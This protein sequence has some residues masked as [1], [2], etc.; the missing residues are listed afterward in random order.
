MSLKVA[1]VLQFRCD[2]CILGTFV[3]GSFPKVASELMLSVDSMADEV[4]AGGLTLVCNALAKV[5]EEA[6][7]AADEFEVTEGSDWDMGVDLVKLIYSRVEQSEVAGID[8][9]SGKWDEFGCGDQEVLAEIRD[10]L[11]QFF[12]A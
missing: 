1:H 12:A 3:A 2:D 11:S 6:A 7:N 8:P 10:A 5:C 9:E 4:D